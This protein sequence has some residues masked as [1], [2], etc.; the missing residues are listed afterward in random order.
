MFYAPVVTYMCVY[1]RAAR[2]KTTMLNFSV[3]MIFQYINIDYLLNRHVLQVKFLGEHKA[4]LLS[5]PAF[6][7]DANSL[8][9]QFQ[10]CL[11]GNDFIAV[12]K[13]HIQPYLNVNTGEYAFDDSSTGT[14]DHEMILSEVPSGNG[15][16]R[17][18]DSSV[19]VPATKLARKQLSDSQ[20]ETQMDREIQK[21]FLGMAYKLANSYQQ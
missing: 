1:A 13:S 21:H 5:L 6:V 11:K 16:K 8:S 18:N 19:I 14:S 3:Y 2:V 4:R 15:K 17:K 12:W 9:K 20:D 10:G 7:A